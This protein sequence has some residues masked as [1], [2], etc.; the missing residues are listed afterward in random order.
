MKKIGLVFI[1]FSLLNCASSSAGI[2]TSNIPV[3]NKPYKILGPVQ[4]RQ[5]WT[6]LDF[7]IVAVPLQRP[8]IDEVIERA[9]KS[10]E[11]D[12]LINIKFW[13][14]KIIIF[15]IT[16]NR[17]GLSAEAIKFEGGEQAPV[18]AKKTR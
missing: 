11:A 16:I 3:I 4:E 15:F 18:N 2:T 7:A 10:Q 12:A 14:D 5:S 17:F 1:L 9:I 8:P 6:T 13:N